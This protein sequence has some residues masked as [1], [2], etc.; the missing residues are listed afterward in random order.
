MRLVLLYGLPGVGKLSVARELAALT[1]YRLFHNHLTVDLVT[2]VFDFGSEPFV[3][4]REEIWLSVISR[5]V[6]EALPGLIFTFVFER[7]VRDGFLER[8]IDAVE[9]HGGEVLLVELQCAPEEL[10]RRLADPGRAAFGKLRSVELYRQLSQDGAFDIPPLPR[11]PLVIDTTWL[12]P[13][14]AARAICA[15]LR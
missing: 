12:S 3:D 4:L 10:E 13:G 9:D 14:E 8:L 11:K 1:G 15:G 5:A 6:V 2:S 7:T